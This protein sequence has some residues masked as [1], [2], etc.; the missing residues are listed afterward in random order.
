MGGGRRGGGG[1]GGGQSKRKI[2][3]NEK[4]K[5]LRKAH[6]SELQKMYAPQ[7]TVSHDRIDCLLLPNPTKE[8]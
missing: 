7:I 5:Q 1:G 8:T 2:N 6:V 4:W 3:K